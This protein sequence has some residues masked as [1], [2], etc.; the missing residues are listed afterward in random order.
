MGILLLLPFLV[1]GYYICAHHP[2][3]KLRLHQYQG[4]LLY[5]LVA[6]EG[7][8]CFFLASV[9]S[10]LLSA[11]SFLQLDW[12]S[13]RTGAHHVS[14]DYISLLETWLIDHGVADVK[15]A[16]IWVFSLQAAALCLVI[17]VFWTKWCAWKLKREYDIDDAEQLETRLLCDVVKGNPQLDL[18]MT[19]VRKPDQKY[20]FSMD[21]R[22]IYIGNVISTGKAS[23]SEGVDQHFLLIPFLSGYREKDTLKVELTTDYANAGALTILLRQENIVSATLWDQK[24][25]EEFQ[26][27]QAHKNEL[28]NPSDSP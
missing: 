4:Q 20:M 12:I 5:L 27:A 21:D 24:V 14:L 9:A 2:L 15:N 10:L 25:W 7:I 26:K 8:R 19:S 13:A 6:R 1:S 17:P 28:K 22:K 3:L 16:N 18:L 11:L 23:E